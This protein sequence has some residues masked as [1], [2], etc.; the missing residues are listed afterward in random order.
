MCTNIATHQI[1]AYKDG[2]RMPT[3]TK[4]VCT[5]HLRKYEHEQWKEFVAYHIETF[6]LTRQAFCDPKIPCEA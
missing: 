3:F 5:D 4:H 2:N 1:V 6:R